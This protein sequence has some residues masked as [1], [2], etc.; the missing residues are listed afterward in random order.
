MP[1][2]EKGQTRPPPVRLSVIIPA[3]NEADH[4]PALLADLGRQQDLDLEII[5]AD[6]GSTDTTEAIAGSGGAR[7]VRCPRGRGA[8]MNAAAQQAGGDYLLFLHADS[9]LDDPQLLGK[10]LETLLAAERDHPWTAGHFRLRFTRSDRRNALA[11]RYLEEKTALNRADTVNGDQ[12]MLLSHRFFHHLGG[13]DHSLPF[14][15]D[16]RIAGKIRSSGRWITLPGSLSTSARRFESEGF[17]RRY[18]L[19]GVIMGLYSIGEWRFFIRAPEVYRVQEET[20][21]LQLAP[22]LALLWS[23]VLREWGLAGTFRTFYRLGRYIRGNSWQLFFF[24]DV[25]LRPLLGPE[26]S[27][28]LRLHDRI[29]APCIDFRVVYG[30]VGLGCFIWYLCILA[31]FFYLQENLTRIRQNGRQR[32]EPVR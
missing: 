30:L 31:P 25:W 19:M 14:L 20:G 3:L 17:H 21:R 1:M 29:V 26:R 2:S 16:Q 24:F 10:A 15:E 12:G 6:G 13:F 8:Q 27:P 11:Y 5:I 18:L 23:M 4:L 9:R 32:H 22:I 7:F 28:L